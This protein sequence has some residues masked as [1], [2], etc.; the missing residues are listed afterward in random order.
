MRTV[1]VLGGMGPAATL[2]FMAK[3][4]AA[5]GAQ[6]DQD[7]VPLLVDLN[8]QVPDR[9]A[10]LRGEG[11]SPEPVLVAMARRLEAAGADGLVIVCNSAHAWAGA[12]QAAVSIPLLH[13]VE[14]SADAVRRDAPGADRV[15]LLAA[16]A[17]LDAQ[18]YQ[19]ALAAR[20]VEPL[21]LEGE[22]RA[23]FMAL[24]YRIKAG[25]A[26]PDE[27]AE[28]AALAQVL[29]GRGAQAILSGCTEAPIVL[30]PGDVPVP[31]IDSTAVLVAET[32]RFARA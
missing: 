12:I 30:A 25:A 32:L 11:P 18:L 16:S 8:P 26:G 6:R 2:D 1:G 13:L 17:A 31:L 19:E 15:G 27:R 21:T 20:G 5:T 28:M 29:I 4:Q 24:L 3:L 7:H 22:D 10:A 9:N 23:R 14:K